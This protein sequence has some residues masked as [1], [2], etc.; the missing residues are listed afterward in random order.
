MKKTE[1]NE[2][3]SENME[4]VEKS[5]QKFF[6]RLG[7]KLSLGSV[8]KPFRFVSIFSESNQIGSIEVE[9]MQILRKLWPINGSL[10]FCILL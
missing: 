4:K 5:E 2:K 10:E 3:K 1:K 7:R 6:P 8:F 9:K